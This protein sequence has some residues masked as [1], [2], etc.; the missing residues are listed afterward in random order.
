M[1]NLEE[2][3]NSVL[4]SKTD[5]FKEIIKK[6][7]NVRPSDRQLSWQQME[8][9]AFIHFGITTYMDIEWGLGD[10]DISIF[11]PTS[12]D[13]NQWV[14]VC[15]SAGMKGIILTCKHIDG[16]CLW[17]SN[18]TEYSIKNTP[19]KNGQGDI[20]QEL[21]DACRKND[22]KFG[23]YLA[24]WDRHE[25]TYG[26]QQYNDYYKNQ[27]RELLTNYGEI[28]N[29]WLDGACGEGPNGKKQVYDYVGFYE[30]IRELQPN[31]V[32]ANCG[33]DVRWCGNEAGHSRESEWSVVPDTFANLELIKENSQH[34]DDGEF[35]KRI[36]ERDADL[37]SRNIIKNAKRLI[38][39]PCEVD[40]S[41]RPGWFYHPNE[42]D[43]VRSLDE[44]LNIYYDSVGGNSC[45]LLNIPPDK[46]GLIHEND[47]KRLKKLGDVIEKTFKDNL[48]AN[49]SAIA[50]E[51]LDKEHDVNNIFD[52]DT[53]TYW[54]PKEGTERAVVEIDL[55]EEKEFDKIVIMENIL[56]GQR[57]ES[58]KIE[59]IAEGEKWRE[60]YKR[61]VVGYKRICCFEPVKARYLRL[62]IE[63]SRWCPTI[64]FIGLYKSQC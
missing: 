54:C 9:Y 33:P 30:L 57:I 50:S 47:A 24:P 56:L 23:V 31:A 26:T 53:G 10:E 37:G 7:A 18:Y 29:V 45:L 38:W 27:L 48:T 41:I 49:A 58:F 4:I 55:S 16:F 20:V 62:T 3:Q 36:N 35:V 13:V 40:T 28:F 34:E 5:N 15:K 43:K 11:N 59:C 51:T 17:P 1:T 2:K 42:D 32:I 6:A 22:M 60:I 39:Y 19:Y 25:E 61:T 64:E 44:L 46:S 8:F 52:K 63:E 14:D 21:S 12:L